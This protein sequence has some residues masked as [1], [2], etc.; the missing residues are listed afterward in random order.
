MYIEKHPSLTNRMM[1]VNAEPNTPE[2][3]TL[4]RNN[5]KDTENIKEFVRKGY[6]VCKRADADTKEARANDYRSFIAACASGAQIIT[7]DY[8]QKSVFF[9][10]DYHIRFDDKTYVRMNP[11]FE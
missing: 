4:I 6:T 2:A 3:A 10:S 1:F 8:Y 5:P 7:T 9:D 11:L